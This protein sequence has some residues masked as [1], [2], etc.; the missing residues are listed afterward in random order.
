[1]LYLDNRESVGKT[2]SFFYYRSNG[3]C[4][5]KYPSIASYETIYTQNK[6][7]Q[8]TIRHKDVK[9]LSECLGL[10]EEMGL[11]ELFSFFFEGKVRSDFDMVEVLFRGMLVDSDWCFC[12]KVGV[13]FCWFGVGSRSIVKLGTMQFSEQVSKY[14]VGKFIKRLRYNIVKSGVNLSKIKF[15]VWS[16]DD[17]GYEFSNYI[18]QYDCLNTFFSSVEGLRGLGIESI[19]HFLSKTATL[20]YQVTAETFVDCLNDSFTALRLNQVDGVLYSRNT[21]YKDYSTCVSPIVDKSG[22]RYGIILDCEGQMGGDG[23]ITAGCRELG[24][25]IYCRYNSILT[26]IDTFSCD[27]LLLEDTLL[28][29]IKNYKDFVSPFVKSIDVLCYGSSDE[30][31]LKSSIS[32]IPSNKSRKLLSST[33]KY[34]NCRPFISNYLM[35]NEVYVENRQTLGNIAKALGVKPLYPKHKPL[36]D[37]RTLFNILAQILMI[38]DSFCI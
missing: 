35:I 11:Y 7:L 26:S 27:T 5:N 15:L 6:E 34:F 19:M 8:K 16:E 2:D 24:G 12:L 25:I 31:M 36:N 38:T 22:C 37:A 4:G 20:K 17:I 21:Y 3:D 14:T 23:S 10:K 29:V 18:L 1:M 9:I 32:M 33:F 28:Q 30:V 13:T